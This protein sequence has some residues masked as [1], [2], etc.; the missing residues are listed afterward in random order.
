LFTN[1]AGC[2]ISET[3]K[4]V[5]QDVLWQ[6][7]IYSKLTFMQMSASDLYFKDNMFDL[8]ISKSVFEHVKKPEQALQEIYRVLRPGGYVFI[9]W[10]PFTSLIMGGHDVGIAY[11]YPWAHLRLSPE[12]HIEKLREVYSN[13][14][15]YDTMPDP[16]RPSD[17][18]AK[19]YAADPGYLRRT[20][21]EDLNKMRSGDFLNF[22][23]KIGFEV[24][25]EYYNSFEKDKKYL[26]DAIRKELS[27]YSEEELLM[28]GMYTVFRKP[29]KVKALGF[30]ILESI[31][32]FIMSVNGVSFNLTNYTDPEEVWVKGI[33]KD[34]A[35]AFFVKNTTQTK[36]IFKVG[37]MVSFTDG[38]KRTITEVKENRNSLIVTLNGRPLDGNKIGYPN[39]I[40]IR[41]K[42]KKG[43]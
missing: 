36:N 34:W 7:E 2:S 35:A 38:T 24:V 1:L 3:V 41:A 37:K 32:N 26:T 10:N 31:M 5:T 23:K 29:I 11:Y 4:F 33:A 30:K 16:H 6:D 28:V 42:A 18:L 22:A 14:N 40:K 21:L 19:K 43:K 15:I 12:E 13:K 27:Q 9:T 8:I 17:E 25:Y 39:I 20:S